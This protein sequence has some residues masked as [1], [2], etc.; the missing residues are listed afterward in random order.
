MTFDKVNKFHF[1]INYLLFIA[2]GINV[3]LPG[4]ARQ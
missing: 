3:Y 1:N 2:G 4:L